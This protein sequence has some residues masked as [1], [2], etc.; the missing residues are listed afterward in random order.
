MGKGA[1]FSPVPLGPLRVLDGLVRLGMAGAGEL[2]EALGVTTA[3]VRGHLN[4]LL[5]SELVEV[6]F[7]RSGAAG[8]RERVWRATP[9]GL[10]QARPR[11]SSYLL[12][13]FLLAMKASLGM[14]GLAELL[15]EAARQLARTHPISEGA[16]FPERVHHLRD[17][18][19]ELGVATRHWEEGEIQK[20]LLK[21]Y[22]LTPEFSR[23]PETYAFHRA[24]AEEVLGVEVEIE[25]AADPR[26]GVC[27][28]RFRK[29]APRGRNRS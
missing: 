1:R 10:S 24:L 23:Y 12:S 13:A 21:N 5:R 29:P 17:L 19:D 9:S 20:L 14:R 22:L 4:S 2:A 25:L 7:R 27:V 3:A 6:A 26:Q 15:A 18:L 16:S 8:P 28:L 11:R